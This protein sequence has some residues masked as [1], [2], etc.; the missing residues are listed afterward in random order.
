[1]FIKRIDEETGE[2]IYINSNEITEVFS[3]D[4]D[5]YIRTTNTDEYQIDEETKRQLV[6]EAAPRNKKTR[7]KKEKNNKEDKGKE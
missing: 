4:E 1:M 2:T 3:Y 7:A 6:G 5:W